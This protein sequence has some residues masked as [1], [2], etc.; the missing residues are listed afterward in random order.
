MP[1]TEIRPTRLPAGIREHP[2]NPIDPE[3]RRKAQAWVKEN[4]LT[5][6]F[7]NLYAITR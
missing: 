4:T 6:H 5:A 1:P 7:G 2:L 3:R